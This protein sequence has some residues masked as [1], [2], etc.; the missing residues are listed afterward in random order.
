MCIDAKRTY[1]GKTGGG[2][3]KTAEVCK[4]RAGSFEVFILDGKYLA[5]KT[6]DGDLL[7]HD[8]DEKHYLLL[9]DRAK[10]KLDKL[11]ETREKM[12]EKEGF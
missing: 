10:R 3:L 6:I 11:I 5:D 7:I 2:I 4:T 8:Y 1:K 12:Y 9:S